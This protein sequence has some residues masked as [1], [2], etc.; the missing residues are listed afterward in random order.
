MRTAVLT[1]SCD[2]IVVDLLLYSPPLLLLLLMT[3]TMLLFCQ[4][5]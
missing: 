2:V 4:A 1:W 3:M 5:H